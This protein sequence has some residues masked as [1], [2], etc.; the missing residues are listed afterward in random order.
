MVLLYFSVV[1]GGGYGDSR[2]EG[3]EQIQFEFTSY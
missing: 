2:S 1:V 3:Q